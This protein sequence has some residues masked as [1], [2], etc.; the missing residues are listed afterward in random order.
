MDEST[1][2]VLLAGGDARRFP[3]KLEQPI[4]GEPMILRCYRN[5][6]ATGLPVYVAAREE[7]SRAV[8]ARLDGP[9]LMDRDPGAGPLRAFAS[10]C[11]AIRAERCFA[12]AA[13]QPRLDASV[14]RRLLAAW[15]PHDEA[16]IPVHDERIEPLAGLY[17]R[18]AVVR[19]DARLRHEGKTAMRELVERLATRFV[20]V[21]AGY[22]YNVNRPS[23]LAG[24]AARR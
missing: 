3:R 18:A 15:R 20:A 9:R 4:D 2:I 16:V 14:L 23:D 10:A 12:I 7:F 8:D 22:F 24:A 17:D 21:E 19:E 5:L 11:E 1:A 13:D 6:R